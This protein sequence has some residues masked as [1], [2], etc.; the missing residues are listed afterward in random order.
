[1][2]G[3]ARKGRLAG[4]GSVVEHLPSTCETLGSVPALK[5]KEKER[6]A[7]RGEKKRREGV[8]LALSEETAYKK[9]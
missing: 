2:L 6:E 5:G 7:S 3:E 9:S 1:M 4:W 8:F